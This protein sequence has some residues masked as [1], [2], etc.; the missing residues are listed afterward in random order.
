MVFLSH[1][2]LIPLLPALGAATMLFFGRKLQK[3]TINAVCVGAVV[4]RVPLLV[5]RSLAIYG[6]RSRQSRQALP[7]HRLHVARHR[8]WSRRASRPSSQAGKPQPPNN[9]SHTRRSPSSVSSRRRF[10][11]RSTF[12]HLAAVCNRRRRSHPHLL[13]WLHGART[14]GITVSSDTSTCSCFP[15]SR[16]FWRTITS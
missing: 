2:W 14:A 10:P 5:W 12:Q 7:K 15:C 6:L 8:Q 13:D 11:A 4:A 9:L 16:S 1:I 3:T